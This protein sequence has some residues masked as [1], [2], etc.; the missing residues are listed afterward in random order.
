[1]HVD[2][3]AVD[4]AIIDL[5]SRNG[6]FTM[7]RL[8]EHMGVGPHD[9]DAKHIA[10]RVHR[11]YK[12]LGILKTDGIGKR[13]MEYSIRDAKLKAFEARLVGSLPG[14]DEAPIK[15]LARLADLEELRSTVMTMAKRVERMEKMLDELHTGLFTPSR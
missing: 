7:A 14:P 5:N 12:R 10:N 8:R 4:R 6:R 9:T 15:K 3:K 11:L 2:M 13:N 1:M